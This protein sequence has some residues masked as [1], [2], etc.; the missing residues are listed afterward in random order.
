MIAAA[1][2]AFAIKFNETTPRE[3][4]GLAALAAIAAIISVIFAMDRASTSSRA[5][6]TA[7]QAAAD[8]AS[9]QTTFQD[10]TYRRRL[11]VAAGDVWRWSRGEDAFAGEEILTELETL[12]LQSGLNGPRIALIEQ[13]P[14]QG[15]IGRLEASVTADFDWGSFLALLEAFEASDLSFAVRSIDVGEEEEGAQRLTFVVS[16]PLINTDDPS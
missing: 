4:A 5:A 14:Q 16:V 12:C 3:R 6:R 8:V 7:T 13:A 9:L 1:A 11:S 15:R 2:R 10:E